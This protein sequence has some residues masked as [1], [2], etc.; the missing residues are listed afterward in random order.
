MNH[1]FQ[2]SVKCVA[3]ICGHQ[4][5]SCVHRILSMVLQCKTWKCTHVLY[6]VYYPFTLS[7]TQHELHVLCPKIRLGGSQACSLSNP[8]RLAVQYINST[9]I[10]VDS[11]M[12]TLWGIACKQPVETPH[13]LVWPP[14]LQSLTFLHMASQNQEK[15]ANHQSSVSFMKWNPVLQWFWCSTVLY[16]LY[17][18]YLPYHAY[19]IV[20]CSSKVWT[21][22]S[23]EFFK[24][25]K[26]LFMHTLQWFMVQYFS[27]PRE[28]TL[29][30][31]CVVCCVVCTHAVFI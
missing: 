14:W 12:L 24:K 17:L 29:I 1:P 13:N 23:S 26:I 27:H 22:Q 2:Q 31:L 30:P 18:L 28:C 6:V 7:R 10:V 25:F 20:S 16:V 21:M 4:L 8:L 11:G 5:H 15:S 3:E 19:S 9:Y